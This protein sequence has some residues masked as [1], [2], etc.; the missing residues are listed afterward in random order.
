MYS[1]ELNDFTGWSKK[2]ETK[3]G[4]K[5]PGAKKPGSKK[6]RSYRKSIGQNYRNSGALAVTTQPAQSTKTDFLSWNSWKSWCE[7]NYFGFVFV[8]EVTLVV[9]F[10]CIH[11][12]IFVFATFACY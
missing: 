7:A 8:M 2:K 3:P 9:S 1:H 6:P 11:Y 12:I 5:K 10:F 4:A